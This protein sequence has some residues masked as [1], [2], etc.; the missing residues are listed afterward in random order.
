MAGWDAFLTEQ[1]KQHAA[2][3]GKKA[4]DGFGE[5]PV[6]LVIDVFYAALGHERKPLLESIRDWPMSC[7]L[8]GWE[9]VDRMVG[10]IDAAR[11]NNVPVIYVRALPGFP[12]FRFSP[13]INLFDMHQKYADVIDVKTAAEYFSSIGKRASSGTATLQS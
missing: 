10:L 5:K 1:D 2:V 3:W 13:W 7:G 12:R 8:E 11:T 6:L 4:P 9:A